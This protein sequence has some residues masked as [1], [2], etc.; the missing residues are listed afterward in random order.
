MIK[1]NFCISIN[2]INFHFNIRTSILY[3]R[4]SMQQQQQQQQ[5]ASCINKST[6]VADNLNDIKAYISICS[7]CIFSLPACLLLVLYAANVTMFVGRKK[8]ITHASLSVVCYSLIFII[9]ILRL[10]RMKQVGCAF[11]S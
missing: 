2:I 7:I 8:F 6:V 3:R 10:N 5:P 9:F 11:S 4:D 1:N